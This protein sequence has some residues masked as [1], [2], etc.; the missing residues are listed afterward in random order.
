[1]HGKTYGAELHTEYRVLDRWRLDAAYTYLDI[2]L[3][4]DLDVADEFRLYEDVENDSP[5]HEFSIR[6]LLDI[7]HSLALDLW[8]RY[9]DELPNQLVKSYVSLDAR[10]GWNPMEKRKYQSSVR[11]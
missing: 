5:K 1:M 6:S 10:M 11:I 8:L 9:T 2:E 4:H 3:I 7:T